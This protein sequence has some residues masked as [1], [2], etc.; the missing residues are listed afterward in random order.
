V[1]LQRGAG[2]LAAYLAAH[3][4]LCLLPPFAIAGAMSAL[5]PK[6]SITRW[7]G[8]RTPARPSYPAAA[9]AGSL[10]VRLL[11]LIGVFMYFPTL[12]EVPVAHMFLDLGMHRGPLLAYLMA[13]PALSLQS[14][15]MVAAII[16][17]AKT[18]WRLGK[19]ALVRI[20]K[21][22]PAWGPGNAA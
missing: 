5:I 11:V 2:N 21:P 18:G 17:R 7:L 14:M 4:L 12:V 22:R 9:A 16:G 19:T 13:D 10:L 6:A 15:L 1:Y 3:V 8:R 20:G